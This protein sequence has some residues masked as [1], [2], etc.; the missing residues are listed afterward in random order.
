MSR[1]PPQL[2]RAA[3][4]LGQDNEYVYKELLGITD[5]EYQQLIAERHVG[6]EYL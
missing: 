3:P 5:D 4:T 1:T 2:W 6:T